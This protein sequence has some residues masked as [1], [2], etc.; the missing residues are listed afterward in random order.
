MKVSIILPA[1]KI[2]RSNEI[3]LKK[4]FDHIQNM[5]EYKFEILLVP[6]L[7]PEPSTAAYIKALF[8]DLII[9]SVAP[10]IGKG[11]AIKKG[12]SDSTGDYIFMVDCDVPY[13][14]VFLD[15]ALA[16]LDKGYDFVTA[17]RRLKDSRFVI[18]AELMG[19]AYRRHRLGLFYNK[20]L[21]SIFRIQSSDTQAGIK[22]MSREFADR[23]FQLQICRGFHFDIEL[24]LV[25]N[26]QGF[27]WMELPVVLIL[28]HEKSTV[29]ILREGISLIYW[30]TRIFLSD[31]K[32]LYT[33]GKKSDRSER[34]KNGDPKIPSK[35]NLDFPDSKDSQQTR[36]HSTGRKN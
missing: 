2:S 36:S 29:R 11:S 31:L 20:L 5:A 28:N 24:F 35:L 15:E 8:P 23:A 30:L 13:D 26:K 16:L 14:L 27:L 7:P 32:G 19:V 33:A 25:C 6:N 3:G 22:G 17:N 18:P 9:T 10:W 4:I 1:K 21:R 12:F 34:V